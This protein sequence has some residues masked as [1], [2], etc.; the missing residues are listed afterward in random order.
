[1]KPFEKQRSLRTLFGRELPSDHEGR[2]N[3]L[4]V[5]KDRLEDRKVI[6][7][8]SALHDE[9]KRGGNFYFLTLVLDIPA[10]PRVDMQQM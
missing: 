1:M 2:E 7:G 4:L 8:S 6:P 3:H 10:A 5:P 9:V